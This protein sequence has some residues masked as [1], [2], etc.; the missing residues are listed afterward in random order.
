[1]DFFTAWHGEKSEIGQ[2]LIWSTRLVQRGPACYYDSE[3]ADLVE[4]PS[5][6]SSL[7]SHNPGLS[8]D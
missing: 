6:S 3:V 2:R 1:M 8:D 4:S 5:S 7:S